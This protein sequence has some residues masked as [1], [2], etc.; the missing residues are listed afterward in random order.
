MSGENETRDDDAALRI[1]EN[2]YE[3]GDDDAAPV[4]DAALARM[5]TAI[6]GAFD[7]AWKKVH[8]KAEAEA[9]APRPVANRL[10]NAAGMTRTALL[11]RLA[12]LRELLGMQLQVAYRN[13]RGEMSDD[14]LRAL[15]EDLENAAA[16]REQGV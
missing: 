11:K 2:V 6:D 16:R 5:R 10:R 12:E 8:E 1:L 9:K 4:D 3:G 14:D 13:S 7:R 15:V